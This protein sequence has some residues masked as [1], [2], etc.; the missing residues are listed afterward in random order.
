MTSK[1]RFV[2]S[3]RLMCPGTWSIEAPILRSGLSSNHNSGGKSMTLAMAFNFSKPG[4]SILPF[5]KQVGDVRARDDTTR[6]LIDLL[7]APPAPVR[8]AVHL[9]EALELLRDM[10]LSPPPPPH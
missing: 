3:A 8:T 9:Q 7:A 4:F 5:R 1:R 10:H 2:F 6:R